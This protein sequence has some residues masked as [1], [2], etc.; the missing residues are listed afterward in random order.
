MKK[1]FLALM[2]SILPI[3]AL[4]AEKLG[5][6]DIK[7]L[8]AAGLSTETVVAKI[9]ISETDFNTDVTDL[10]SLKNEG[11]PS[12]VIAAMVSASGR[13][14]EKPKPL[15][16]TSPDPME[17]H[18]A[19]VYLIDHMDPK[20][21]L[22][23]IDS[24]MTSQTKT[25]GIL[26][27]ALTGGIASA[28]LKAVIP[29]ESAKVDSPIGKPEFYFFFDSSNNVEGSGQS[30][31]FAAGAAISVQSPNEFSLIKLKRKKDRREARFGSFNIAGAKT[32]VMDKDRI[33]FNYEEIRTGVFKV[34]PQAELKS[35]E[36]GFIYAVSAGTG[37]GIMAAGTATGRIFGFTVE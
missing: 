25:G 12:A 2:L 32:G 33:P 14:A 35:G 17:P 21:D 11:I 9:E 13:Q 29:G 22:A 20:A 26:G 3:Y 27:Y 36:Y 34:T 31:V 5:N 6:D 30:G 23:R 28:S 19:G 16:A 1:A 4:H 7:G 18:F 10:I 24:M 37:P 8:L 15:S